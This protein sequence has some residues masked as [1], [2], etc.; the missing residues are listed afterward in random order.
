MSK[1]KYFQRANF[2]GNFDSRWCKCRVLNY[3]R[4]ENSSDLGSF[5][6]R[7]KGSEAQLL[8]YPTKYRRNNYNISY[9]SFDLDNGV[10]G[11]GTFALGEICD[12][13]STQVEIPA[14]TKTT[15][16]GIASTYRSSKVL[17]EFNSNTGVYSF[18]ELNIIH[19][20]TTVEILEYGDISLTLDQ[21]F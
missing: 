15:I 8:F 6:F 16:V 10:S 9:C 11:I 5:D 18:N 7:I 21:M 12:I 4:V 3:G 2:S 20:G 14:S 13:E 19:D 1:I 17:V